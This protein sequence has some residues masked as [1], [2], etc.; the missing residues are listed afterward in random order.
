MSNAKFI[1]I[2][3]SVTTGLLSGLPRRI[4]FATR[5]TITGYTPNALTGLIAVTA[6]M[7]DAFIA[8]NPTALATA[9]MLATVFGGSI[10]PDMVYILPT[11]GGVLTNAMLNKAN[12]YPRNWSIL[13]VGSQTNGLDDEATYLADCKVASLWCTDSTEKIF[14]MSFSMADAGTLPDELLLA[15]GSGDPGAL[16]TQNRT[17]TLVTNANTEVD[18]GVFV[19]HNPLLAAV[20]HALYGGS[21]AR[22]IG[23]LSD[24]H[25]FTGVDPDTYSA[26]TRAYIALNSLAQYNGAKDQ[27]D[28]AFVYDTFLNDDV[29]PPASL[30]IETQIAI[31]YINDYCVIAPRNALIAAGRTGVPGDYTGV[32]EVAALTRAAL[33][34]LWKAGAILSNEDGTPAFTLITKSAAQIAALDPAW[35]SKGIIPVGAIVATIKPYAATHYYTITFN[36]N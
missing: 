27:G 29:N 33:E 34:T 11:G 8:A 14:I 30:Q 26:A 5:E 36:F 24:A 4:V 16:M 31:D 25:D 10:V 6:D 32:M 35:Q 7:V 9:Q 15:G 23:S 2:A 20:V 12:Y 13:N 22:S 19:Y 18:T 28:A 21:I 3:S 17:M 1:T